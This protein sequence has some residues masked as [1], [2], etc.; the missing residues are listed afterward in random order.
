MT[1]SETFS[2]GDVVI[3]PF[4]FTEREAAKR[5]PA[6]VCSASDFNA[7]SKHVVLAMITTSTAAA[8]PGDVRIKDLKVAGLPRDST[9]RWKLFTLDAS[10]ILR[11]AGAL[12]DADR[13]SCRRGMPIAL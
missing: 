5:R 9:V 10:L 3:V 7:R 2:P 8:W 12:G 4:P 6:L 13:A 1:R 11:R